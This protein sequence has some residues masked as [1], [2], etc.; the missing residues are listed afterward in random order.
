MKSSMYGDLCLVRS[1]GNGCLIHRDK[2]GRFVMLHTA[3]PED[4]TPAATL[5]GA[6][7]ACRGLER[8][9]PPLPARETPC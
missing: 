3:A 5:A 7:A 4:G 1:T 6:H 9:K 8:S 2:E